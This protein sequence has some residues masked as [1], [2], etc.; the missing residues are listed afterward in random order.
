MPFDLMQIY[1]AA[2]QR[3]LAQKELSLREQA[4]LNDRLFREKDLGFRQTQFME[5][6]AQAERDRAERQQQQATENRLAMAD[7]LASGKVKPGSATLTP[8]R[9]GQAPL[10]ILAQPTTIEAPDAMEMVAGMPK[11]VPVSPEERART[12]AGIELEGKLAAQKQAFQQRMNQLRE[13]QTRFPKIFKRYPQLEG[14]LLTNMMPTDERSW[15]AS[16]RDYLDI[17]YDP[18]SS[19]EDVQSAKSAFEATSD[20]MRMENLARTPQ[21][22]PNFLHDLDVERAADKLWRKAYSNAIAADPNLDTK[23]AKIRSETLINHLQKEAMNLPAGISSEALYRA[24]RNVTNKSLS[25]L[26]GIEGRNAP[27]D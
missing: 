27:I 20:L 7:L 23:P 16:M 17:I 26:E 13:A 10:D 24:Q 4:E 2:K 3:A 5:G 18:E 21:P 12:M 22:S 6:L 8:P 25:V 15:A 14:A 19:A 1:H 9:T 11:V